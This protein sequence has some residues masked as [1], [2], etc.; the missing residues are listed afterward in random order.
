[1]LKWVQIIFMIQ[2]IYRFFDKVEDKVRFLLSHYPI[3]YAF[4]GAFGTIA[5]W[6]GCWH[7]V[8]AIAEQMLPTR[9]FPLLNPFL[10]L[11]FGMTIL[12]LSGLFVSNFIG[13]EI[14]IS[15]LRGSKKTTEKTESEV[16]IDIEVSDKIQNQLQ[17]LTTQITRLQTDLNK[18]HSMVTKT[19][20]IRGKK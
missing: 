20:K 13:N 7:V 14:I 9:D 3:I 17:T 2:Q 1:M 18:I 19:P 12:L 5:F 8:D 11:A 6:R 10:S 16:R 4:I 15:G